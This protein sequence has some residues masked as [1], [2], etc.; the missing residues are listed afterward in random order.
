MVEVGDLI[1][2]FC[3]I[4]KYQKAV[5]KALG[6]VELL[7]I[8]LGQFYAVPL[9]IG[10]RA[11]AQVNCHIEDPAL[12]DPDQLALRVLLL[13]VEATK[14]TLDGH[15]LVVLNEDHVQT[16][17]LHIPLVIS[18]DEIATAV[19]MDGRFDDVEAL[20]GAFGNFDLTHGHTS[21]SFKYLSKASCHVGRGAKP[22]CISLLL[23]KRLL[24]GRAA[25]LR[26]YSAVVTGVTLVV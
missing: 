2:E 9:A 8:L 15:A 16:L 25:L 23:S 17:F 22:I 18:F 1:A 20:D 5:G 12:D 21:I 4:G 24:K 6:D 7:L 3:R 13:E 11:G 10:G 14:D 26:P 19:A